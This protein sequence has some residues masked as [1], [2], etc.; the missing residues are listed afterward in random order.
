MSM[1]DVYASFLIFVVT[2]IFSR[3]VGEELLSSLLIAGVPTVSW[4]IGI[5]AERI[6]GYLVSKLYGDK[7]LEEKVVINKAYSKRV[8][9][10]VPL[11]V[12]F[13]TLV[14]LNGIYQ[15]YVVMATV[16]IIVPFD[17]SLSWQARIGLFSE[18]D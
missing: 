5:L 4:V 8:V 16:F 2:A 7:R 11:I 18:Y 10:V 15:G 17:I 14:L 13:I 3:L 12:S 6:C 9:L 1:G